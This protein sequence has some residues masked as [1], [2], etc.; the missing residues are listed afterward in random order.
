MSTREGPQR[1]EPGRLWT[2]A[3]GGSRQGRIVD[4][5]TFEP[6]DTKGER[7][8]VEVFLR[9]GPEGLVFDARC[10]L[11]PGGGH[12][13]SDIEA[14]RQQTLATLREL[15]VL[16]TGIVWEDWLE[17]R[18]RGRNGPPL[19]RDANAQEMSIAYSPLRRGR[20]PDFPDRDFTLSDQGHAIP[21]PQP[22]RT[23]AEGPE[24]E[25]SAGRVSFRIGSDRDVDTEYAYLED[26]EAN[27]A[28][29]D[30]LISSLRRL[31]TELANFLTHDNIAHAVTVVANQSWPRLEAPATPR[32]P[33]P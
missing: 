12:S 7:I 14:L 17:V 24:R 22:K 9:Q 13:S 15:A 25:L 23:G 10:P 8:K 16:T 4:R 18:V 29:L 1:Q 32:S 5:W 26:T 2:G 3:A 6:A 20:H 33:K 30:H 21:F 31:R 11:L 27:R 19:A 28:A